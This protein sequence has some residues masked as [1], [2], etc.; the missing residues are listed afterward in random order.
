MSQPPPTAPLASP[1]R[2][3]F[4]DVNIISLNNSTVCRTTTPLPLVSCIIVRASWTRIRQ[5]GSRA[6]DGHLMISRSSWRWIIE[7][8]W[9]KIDELYLHS[10]A[11]SCSQRSSALSHNSSLSIY[12]VSPVAAKKKIQFHPWFRHSLYRMVVRSRNRAKI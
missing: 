4:I 2:T 1:A 7:M 12:I 8:Q 5:V 6:M 11:Q 10:W 3:Y 9:R